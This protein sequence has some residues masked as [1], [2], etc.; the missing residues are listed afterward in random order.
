MAFMKA[1]WFRCLLEMNIPK[2]DKNCQS[3]G[4]EDSVKR[5]SKITEYGGHHKCKQV[6]TRGT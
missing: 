4:K 6:T 2:V 1:E 5:N 3:N